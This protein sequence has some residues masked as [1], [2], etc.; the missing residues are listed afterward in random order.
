MYSHSVVDVR[1]RFRS[2][3]H[4]SFSV[5]GMSIILIVGGI[6]QLTA[7][8]LDELLALLFKFRRL[9]NDEDYNYAYAEWQTGSILQLQRL[10]QEGVGAGAWSGATDL[11]PVTDPGDSLA[12]LNLRER[13]HP[14]LAL[15]SHELTHIVT[16]NSVRKRPTTNHGIILGDENW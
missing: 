11:V 13:E 9:R 6:I 16:N 15:P 10:A 14:R 4:Y 1:Q 8:F 12:V 3:R 5:L 2:S 7:F